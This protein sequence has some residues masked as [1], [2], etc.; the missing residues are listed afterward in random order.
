[1]TASN[2]TISDEQV[3]QA[4]GN[5]LRLGVLVSAF[6]VLAGG[7]LF[8]AGNGSATPHYQVFA[9]QPGEL[10]SVAGIVRAAAELQYRALIQLGFLLLIATPI[11]RVAF[12]IIAFLLQRDRLYVT[13][14]LIVFGVLLYSLLGWH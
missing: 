9:G 1:M 10:R 11:A 3:E 6:L 7:V 14:T 5:L 8:L 4:M 2:R 12:S 13:F